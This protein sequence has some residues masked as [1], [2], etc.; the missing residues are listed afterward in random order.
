MTDKCSGMTFIHKLPLCVFLKFRFQ[1][2]NVNPGSLACDKNALGVLFLVLC[3]YYR[4]LSISE[5]FRISFFKNFGGHQSFLSGHWYPCLDFCWHLPWV[6]KPGWIPPFDTSLPACNGLLIFNTH[7]P[8]DG[9]HGSRTFLL[10]HVFVHV[11]LS[12]L[13]VEKWN[14]N[15]CWRQGL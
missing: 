11:L 13:I 5:Y 2:L 14:A 7:W 1:W 12:Y 6:S 15:L 4:F 8:L 9:Q 10:I 3:F